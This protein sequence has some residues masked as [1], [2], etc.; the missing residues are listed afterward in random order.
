MLMEISLPISNAPSPD[1]Q[2][3]PKFAASRD[4]FQRLSNGEFHYPG[5]Q[6]VL[7][8]KNEADRLV[9]APPPRSTSNTNF[10]ASPEAVAAGPSCDKF[11]FAEASPSRTENVIVKVQ[12]I[13]KGG[14]FG[15][16]QV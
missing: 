4:P 9:G 6:R 12:T 10:S 15:Q 3:A 7:S 5:A 1:V 13:P 11:P 2:S 8:E 14:F 16:E